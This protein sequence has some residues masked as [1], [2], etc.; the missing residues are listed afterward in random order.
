MDDDLKWQLDAMENRDAHLEFGL[1]VLADRARTIDERLRSLERV[2][3][4]VRFDVGGLA[5]D[6][7]E[8]LR[9]LRKVFGEE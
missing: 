2:V 8:V 6:S 4:A 9:L 5:A 7:E 3:G 1:S